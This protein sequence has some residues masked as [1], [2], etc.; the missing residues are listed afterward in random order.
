M[1]PPKAKEQSTRPLSP[2]KNGV[3]LF[4]SDADDISVI[5]REASSAGIAVAALDILRESVEAGL[6]SVKERWKT[7]VAAAK[8]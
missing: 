3:R 1:S 4:K 7:I 2:P 8:K 5:V 6:P